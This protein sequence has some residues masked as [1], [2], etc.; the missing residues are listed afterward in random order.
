MT[1]AGLIKVFQIVTC[2]VIIITADE[3]ATKYNN[4]EM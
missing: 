3:T 2:S 4:D 1:S